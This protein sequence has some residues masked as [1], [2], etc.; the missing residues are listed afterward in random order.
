MHDV[1][2]LVPDHAHQLP[3]VHQIHQR[4][5]YAHASVPAGERVDVGHFVNFEVQFQS[6]DFDILGQPLE[7][8]AVG[9]SV[10]RHGIVA[11][12][13][14]DRLAAEGRYVGIGKRDG[15]YH[16][17]ARLDEFLRVQRFAAQLD[18][19]CASVA[20]SVQT[21][22]ASIVIFLIMVFCC[23][24]VIF[25][26]AAGLFPARIRNRMQI[27]ALYGY[28]VLYGGKW[29]RIFLIDRVRSC[30]G[31]AVFGRMIRQSRCGRKDIFCPYDFFMSSV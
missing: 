3:V 10:G 14:F 16:V 17:G 21:V 13:P 28:H 18:L 12:H 20:Q 24:S 30:M 29:G 27:Y 7:P 25:C 15:F 19:G 26:S 5:E 22:S 23:V 31:S 4:T 1:S 8:L 11:I 9:R 6:V 2:Y